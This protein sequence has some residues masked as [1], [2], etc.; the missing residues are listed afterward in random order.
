MESESVLNRPMAAVTLPLRPRD[1]GG[2]GDYIE[3]MGTLQAE[4]VR[5]GHTWAI[6]LNRAPRRSSIELEQATPAG[7]ERDHGIQRCPKLRST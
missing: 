4:E 2:G 7:R 6:S 1:M 3:A 5:I